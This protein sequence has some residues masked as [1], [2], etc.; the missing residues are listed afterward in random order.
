MAALNAVLG[1][2]FGGGGV[3]WCDGQGWVDAG[4][5]LCGPLAESAVAVVDEGHC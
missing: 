3:A 1:V 2:E 5:V 4:E